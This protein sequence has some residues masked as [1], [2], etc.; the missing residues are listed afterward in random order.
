MENIKD[1]PSKLLPSS[2][3]VEP[4]PVLKYIQPVN[5]D[6]HEQDLEAGS[7]RPSSLRLS[8]EGSADRML[9]KAESVSNEQLTQIE[10]IKVIFSK[11]HSFAL[12]NELK[13]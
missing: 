7:S 10:I 13:V 5:S 12:E 9:L 2:T 6:Y 11:K 1:S 8:P 3:E 4:I